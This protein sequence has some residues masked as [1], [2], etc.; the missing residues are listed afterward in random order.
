MNKVEINLEPVVIATLKTFAKQKIEAGGILLGHRYIDNKG[1][2]FEIIRVTTP[3]SGDIRTA[4][5]FHRKDRRHLMDVSKFHSDTNG[6]GDFIG[7]WH[8]HPNGASTAPSYR[9]F[10]A[11]SFAQ[12]LSKLP[13]VHVI[14]NLH[15]ID[16]YNSRGQNVVTYS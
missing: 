8:T 11:F 6:Y 1:V 12:R 16:L 14:S 4:N 10:K 3:Y 15:Q 9:D 2:K 13:L 5:S 7:E